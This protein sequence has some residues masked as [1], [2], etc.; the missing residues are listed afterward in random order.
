MRFLNLHVDWWIFPKELLNP[1]NSKTVI[2]SA[3]KFPNS[4]SFFVEITRKDL[5]LDP[6]VFDFY[7]GNERDLELSGT[8]GGAVSDKIDVTVSIV[9]G[10]ILYTLIMTSRSEVGIKSTTL[11]Q[12]IRS[13]PQLFEHGQER[14]F[15]KDSRIRPGLRSTSTLTS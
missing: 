13:K 14:N 8:F 15:S 3:S 6:G 12:T 5:I 1:K 4:T 2:K 9:H 7:D 11:S 10:R